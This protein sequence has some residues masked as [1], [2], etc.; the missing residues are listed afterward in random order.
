MAEKEFEI[1]RVADSLATISEIIFRRL[2]CME[3]NLCEPCGPA[4]MAALKTLRETGTPN[5]GGAVKGGG[6]AARQ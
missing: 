1:Q 5:M 3:C 6:G 2:H 4:F